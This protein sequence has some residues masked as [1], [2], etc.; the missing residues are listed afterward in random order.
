MTS[1]TKIV[2][3]RPGFTSITQEEH[4][5]HVECKSMVF[6]NLERGKEEEIQDDGA[7]G[8]VLQV[9]YFFDETQLRGYEEESKKKSLVAGL[10]Y[11]DNY[12]EVLENMEEVRQSL[13]LALVERKIIKYM[14]GLD[15]IIKGFEK[16][17][18][19]FVFEEEKLE[20]LMESKFS[21]LDEVR[22]INIGNELS[23]TYGTGRSLRICFWI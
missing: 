11:I 21:I 17:K 20:E 8:D 5:Y 9:F 3:P 14:Q 1:P 23:I 4:K 2:Y 22:L 15:A 18:F 13:L 10:I 19:L 12:E 7:E 16:D 6:K